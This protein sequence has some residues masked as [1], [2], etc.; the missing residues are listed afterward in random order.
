MNPDPNEVAIIKLVGGLELATLLV[1]AVEAAHA[2]IA[3]EQS[4]LAMHPIET[5]DGE[6]F[7]LTVKHVITK[8]AAALE[9]CKQAQREVVTTTELFTRLSGPTTLD[10]KKLQSTVLMALAQKIFEDEG[11][12]PPSGFKGVLE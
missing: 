2:Y 12:I 3:Q 8:T 11:V 1:A 6:V 5:P 9:A 4:S 7:P 10:L